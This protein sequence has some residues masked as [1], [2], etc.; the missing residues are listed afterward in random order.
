MWHWQQFLVLKHKVLLYSWQIIVAAYPA[1]QCQLKITCK[2]LT[3]SLI[4]N[5]L[6]KRVWPH[7]LPTYKESFIKMVDQKG[8]E[9]S[10]H[11]SSYFWERSYHYILL[12]GNWSLLVV[13]ILY[14]VF[15]WWH[16]Y[17]TNQQCGKI[18]DLL[19]QAHTGYMC[20]RFLE[21]ALVRTCVCVR[22]HPWGHK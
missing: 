15:Y 17:L 21:I 7:A 16:W 20:A 5:S 6:H 14:L 8:W 2:H 18:Q 13:G 12:S 1:N 10:Y 22:V 4:N 3:G 19:N 9:T 11:I